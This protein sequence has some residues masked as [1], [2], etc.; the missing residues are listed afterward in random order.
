M[1][2]KTLKTSHVVAISPVHLRSDCCLA[3]D[4]LPRIC[5]RGTCLPI[6]CLAVGVHV[7]RY[8]RSSLL[9]KLIATFNFFIDFTPIPDC[10]PATDTRARCSCSSVP[11]MAIMFSHLWSLQSI[12]YHEDCTW[13]R[14]KMNR[15]LLLSNRLVL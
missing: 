7:T 9:G 8:Y 6:R 14:N 12:T 4:C 2:R 13:C 5:L 15:K 3:T 10:I 1:A 11:E